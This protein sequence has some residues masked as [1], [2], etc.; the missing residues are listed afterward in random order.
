MTTNYYFPA[1]CYK[2]GVATF[3][4]SD[5]TVSVIDKDNNLLVSDV[6]CTKLTNLTGNYI[7]VYTGADNLVC[8]ANFHTTDITVDQQDVCS[9]TP[10][11]IY[12]IPTTPMLSTDSRLNNLDAT[13]S[14][15]LPT[16]SYLAPDNT[17]IGTINTNVGLIPTNPLLTNDIRLNN[18]DAA[19]SSR[20][21]LDA[22]TVWANPTRTLT[23]IGTMIADIWSYASRTLTTF[24]LSGSLPPTTS[25]DIVFYKYVSQIITLLNVADAQE[26]WVTFKRSANQ[27]D[28]DSVLQV[29]KTGGLLYV[30]GLTAIGAG[31]TSADATLTISGANLLLTPSVA[32]SAVIGAHTGLYGEVK[33]KSVTGVVSVVTQFGVDILST[34]THAV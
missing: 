33:S 13:I 4:S 31:L 11:Q 5:F 12:N 30:N 26:I 3:P 24:V 18:L 16:S 21:V 20:S 2:L 17:T 29:S 9:Y 34:I 23:S 14:S 15:R 27:D 7:Y 22:A 32:L 19:I 8:W 10:Y 6:A 28:K 1:L 25:A